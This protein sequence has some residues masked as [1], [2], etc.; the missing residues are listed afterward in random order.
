M[1]HISN[2]ILFERTIE[3]K[4]SDGVI[5]YIHPS[6][7]RLSKYL[8]SQY[9][10]N[11]T[12]DVNDNDTISQSLI[13]WIYFCYTGK[14]SNKSFELYIINNLYGNC[15][16]NFE[17]FMEN[18]VKRYNL[19]E[20]LQFVETIR[21][22]I[23]ESLLYI[24]SDYF[25]RLKAD[26]LGIESNLLL[27]NECLIIFRESINKIV[28]VVEKREF[29]LNICESFFAQFDLAVIRFCV[30]QDSP[31]ISHST[32]LNNVM[33]LLNLPLYYIEYPKISFKPNKSRFNR[34][35][36]EERCTLIINNKVAWIRPITDHDYK[37]VLTVDIGRWLSNEWLSNEW[38]S[39]EWSSNEIFET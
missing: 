8:S 34:Y 11:F 24:A 13:D 2:E 3:I 19:L 9:V 10:D 22:T 4:L 29:I 28:S 14:D 12:M 16:D 38:S 17:I 23:S 33:K 36:F 15:I 21:S 32:K 6:I 26:M 20:K 39:N 30:Y 1:S 5:I 18:L 7:V 31:I 27:F 37:T 25:K 35:F